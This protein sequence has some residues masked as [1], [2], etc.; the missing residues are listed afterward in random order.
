METAE[1]ERAM[2]AKPPETAAEHAAV[3][4]AEMEEMKRMLRVRWQRCCARCGPA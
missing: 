3:Y 4:A 1:T 2:P